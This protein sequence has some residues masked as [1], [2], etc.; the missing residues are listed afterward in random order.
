MFVYI[1]ENVN[2]L[3]GFRRARRIVFANFEH[4]IFPV[5]LVVKD[6]F[7]HYDSTILLPL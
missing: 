7:C 1:K 5:K 4:G 6:E 2:Y 3:V